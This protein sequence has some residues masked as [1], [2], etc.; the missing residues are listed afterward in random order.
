MPNAVLTGVIA[1]GACGLAL[2][3]VGMTAVVAGGST[4][5][6]IG[7]VLG[8][9][10]LI[11][12]GRVLERR[13]AARITALSLALVQA[14]LGVGLLAHGEMFGLALIPLAGLVV[15]PLSMESVEQ[16]FEPQP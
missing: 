5:A 13:Q 7:G 8:V 2:L 12:V 3:G 6:S 10:E 15:I 11:V 1:L 16:Y 9:A 4:L 14:L